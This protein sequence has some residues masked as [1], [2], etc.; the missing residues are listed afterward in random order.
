[1][2]HDAYGAGLALDEESGRWRV[3]DTEEPLWAESNW[4]AE[5]YAI[6]YPYGAPRVAESLA[7]LGVGLVSGTLTYLV[8]VISRRQYQAALD[9]FKR[10]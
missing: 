3:V 2:L 6:V 8:V 10:L 4:P 5:M 1:M 9:G 7:L